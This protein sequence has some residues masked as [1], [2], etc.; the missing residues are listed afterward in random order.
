MQAILDSNSESNFPVRKLYV[1]LC[2]SFSLYMEVI[3]LPRRMDNSED[4]S[5]GV[6]LKSSE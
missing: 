6:E 4:T 3:T 1:D 5:V 2:F